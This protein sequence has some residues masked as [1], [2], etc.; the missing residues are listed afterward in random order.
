MGRVWTFPVVCAVAA[1]VWPLVAVH[2]SW[3]WSLWLE[4]VPPC[5]PYW[6][7]CTSISRAMRQEPVVY[8]FRGVLLPYGWLL[9][10]FW[11]LSAVWARQVHPAARRR[12]WAMLSCGIV[13]AAFYM[14]YAAFLGGGSDF[15]AKFRLV[16]INL[17]F[18]LTVLAQAWLVGIAATVGVLPAWLRRSFVALLVTLLL[19][20]L[21]TLPPRFIEAV[22]HRPIV[23]AVEWI[24]ALLMGL[25]YP[26]TAVAFARTE[27]RL[28]A[29][30]RA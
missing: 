5:N 17:Y 13:G 23:N 28:T 21:A 30:V 27:F 29:S 18:F 3:L 19:L 25:C 22:D 24:Y 4:L 16:G 11:A 15:A 2:V 26:L 1:G 10:G 20:A 12:R 7:G 6:D 8:W 9:A 14:L